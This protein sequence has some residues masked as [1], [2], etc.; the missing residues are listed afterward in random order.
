MDTE[1][2]L[3]ELEER[4]LDLEAEME[5]LMEAKAKRR[6]Y[7]RNYMRKRRETEREQRKAVRGGV[8][9]AVAPQDPESGAEEGM[10]GPG[11]LRE[12]AS[13]GV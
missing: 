12:G 3:D 5:V 10:E 9:V 2:R 8:G 1:K 13:G 7:M 6:T 4:V 11:L